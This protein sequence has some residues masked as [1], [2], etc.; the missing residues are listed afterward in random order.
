VGRPWSRRENVE[1]VG[2]SAG[3]DGNH[4]TAAKRLSSTFFMLRQSYNELLGP[5]QKQ[6]S[7]DISQA[8]IA[9]TRPYS[10]SGSHSPGIFSADASGKGRAAIN[11]SD[12]S[13]NSSTNPAT[14]ACPNMKVV[15]RSLIDSLSW[16][17]LGRTR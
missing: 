1:A 10:V 2:Q 4:T 16:R 7:T 6:F 9:V 14:H 8:Q 17:L 3:A 12:R 11:N 5:C 15:W 13:L